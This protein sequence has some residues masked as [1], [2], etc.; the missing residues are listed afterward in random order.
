[1]IIRRKAVAI[2]TVALGL[3]FVPVCRLNAEEALRVLVSNGMKAAIEELR[4]ECE[5]AAGRPLELTFHSTA[6]VKK[7]IEAGEE[8]DLTIITSEA[9]ADLIK[10]G[11]LA[12][13][14]RAD[15]VRSELGIGIRKGA[16]KPDI[17]TV[18]ALEHA[19][20]ATKSITYPEDGAGRGYVEKMFERM[21][22]AAKVQPKIILAPGSGLATESI[23]SG[24]A[25][26]VITL[27]SEIVPVAGVEILGPL[28]GEFQYHIRF[29]AAVSAK[30]KHAAAA[31]AIIAY[32]TGPGAASAL[33]AKGLDAY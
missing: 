25:E 16:T 29:S 22:I 6:L 26:M 11:K 9:I 5:R 10:Q 12:A 8:F 23:A 14:S 17:K 7:S 24:K 4:P 20:L 3:F 32:L 15:V 27:F 13:G 21:G 2:A 18:E 31:K 30:S 1:M 33:K 19:L 28:P